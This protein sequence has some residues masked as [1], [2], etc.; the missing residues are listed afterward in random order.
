MLIVLVGQ[1]MGTATGVVK[2]IQ[3]AEN[4]NV[5]V[6]G[7]YVNG[8]NSGS[9]LPTGLPRNRVTAW[10]WSDIASAIDQMMGEGKNK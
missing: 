5:P 10:N 9:T 8:G 1:H 2:E 3:F 4:L 6:F 7:V